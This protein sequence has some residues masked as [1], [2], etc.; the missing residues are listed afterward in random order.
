MWR[1][2]MPGK[3]DTAALEMKDNLAERPDPYR[4]QS[5]NDL[6]NHIAYVRGYAP[7]YFKREDFLLPHEQM[8]LDRAFKLLDDGIEIAY[9]EVAF[10]DKKIKL[11]DALKR[12]IAAYRSGDEVSGAI[13]LQ[14]DFEDKIFKS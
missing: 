13:I 7:K 9:P 1:R 6:W 4:I 12:A 3:R 8:T 2:L 10:A 14:D 5:V 11:R